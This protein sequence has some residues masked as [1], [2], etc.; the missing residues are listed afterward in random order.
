MKIKQIEA[1]VRT[2]NNRFYPA[3]VLQAM[4]NEAQRRVTCRSLLVCD[5]PWPQDDDNPPN[6]ESAI[7][8]VTSLT[9]DGRFVNV[10][11]NL[12]GT[13]VRN[14][15]VGTAPVHLAM[16]GE[17][18]ENKRSITVEKSTITHLLLVQKE[19]PA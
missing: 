3:D 15:K 18:S 7:G 13:D 14:P 8:V 12:L 4:V 17:F 2:V 1:G 16:V 11:Y 5:C 6:I 19:V 10:S 9:F